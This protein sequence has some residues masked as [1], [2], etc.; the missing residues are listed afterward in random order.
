MVCLTRR[1]V[2]HRPEWMEVLNP[3]LQCSP[4]A[5]T[6]H[7]GP[8]EGWTAKELFCLQKEVGEIVLVGWLISNS[9]PPFLRLWT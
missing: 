6:V 5:Q 4:G 3:A 8:L 1:P 7:Q 2:C 9:S